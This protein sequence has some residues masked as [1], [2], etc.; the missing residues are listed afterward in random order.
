MSLTP[1]CVQRGSFAVHRH[2]RRVRPGGRCGPF[3][4]GVE[5]APQQGS[6]PT[7][8]ACSNVR[9]P[10]LHILMCVR[11]LVRSSCS[12][13]SSQYFSASP[14][15]SLPSLHDAPMLR[16][17]YGQPSDT[18]I[19]CAW[20]VGDW[21]RTARSSVLHTE[22]TETRQTSCWCKCAPACPSNLPCA[23]FALTGCRRCPCCHVFP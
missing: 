10:L 1:R 11:P 3:W 6:S 20:W 23:S 15:F 2:Y 21:T 12:F 7:G 16:C 14:S 8:C 19:A 5:E 9:A 22:T 4:Q 17:W 13:P 18:L